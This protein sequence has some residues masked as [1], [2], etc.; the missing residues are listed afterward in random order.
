MDAEALVRD[1]LDRLETEARRRTPEQADE[2]VGGVRE[3]IEA[4]LAEAGRRDE[5][6]I[7]MVLDKLGSPEAIAAAGTAEDGQRGAEP[8]VMTARRDTGGRSLGP[9]E[10]IAL[11]LITFGS[12]VL[13]F[14]G[15]LLG[16]VL[17]WASQR[18]T[19]PVKIGATVVALVL[20]ALPLG[21]FAVSGGA[22]APS[23]ALP[24]ASPH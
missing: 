17:T 1:Y 9:M 6:T 2:I 20:L 23:A 3:H 4:A 14:V 22:A 12:V 5:A 24:I 11:L 16:L 10:I 18:W 13:P 19:V 15:P 8:D 7:R 21:L